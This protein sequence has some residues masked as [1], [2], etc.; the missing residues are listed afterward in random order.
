MVARAE[1]A[2]DEGEDRLL[3]AGRDEDVVGIGRLVERGDLAT[4]ERVAGR[5]RVAEPEVAPEGG[6][7]VVG[8]G[9][10]LGHRPGLDVARA[11]EV[12]NGE[13]PAGEEALELEVGDAHLRIMRASGGFGH[14]A[15]RCAI[16]G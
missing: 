5:F 7:L 2:A 10:E 6:R 13:L 16:A 9:E 12:A 11:E 4:Q 14:L 15:L 8:E 3:R 1:Q